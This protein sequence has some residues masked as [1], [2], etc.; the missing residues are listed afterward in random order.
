MGVDAKISNLI[1]VSEIEKIGIRV[2]FR[3]RCGSIAVGTG[4]QKRPC[5]A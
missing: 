5:H 2:G 4:P 3:D 1:I